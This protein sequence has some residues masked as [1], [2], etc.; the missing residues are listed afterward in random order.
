MATSSDWLGA[1]GAV[2]PAAPPPA[3]CWFEALGHDAG[4][5]EDWPFA[6]LPAPPA[7]VAAAMPADASEAASPPPPDGEDALARAYDEGAA[8]GRAAGLDEARAEARREADHARALRLAFRA[9][10]EA[11]LDVLA[12]EL[13][14]TVM[15]LCSQVLGDYAIDGAALA[16]RCTA[17]AQRLGGGWQGARLHLHPDDLANLPDGALDGWEVAPDAALER[18]SLVI[19]GADGTVRDGPADWRRALAEALRP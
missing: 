2:A 18:G 8:A 7:P 3:P 12:E 15:A 9:L 11:A 19:E 16:A 1:L 10:D 14:H 13:A 5:A 6:R 4:F 17:A